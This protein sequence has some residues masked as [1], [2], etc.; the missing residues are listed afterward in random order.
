MD[1]KHKKKPLISKK[2]LTQAQTQHVGNGKAEGKARGKE[3]G[4]VGG[5]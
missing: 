2:E 4:A 3:G 5:N 1:N